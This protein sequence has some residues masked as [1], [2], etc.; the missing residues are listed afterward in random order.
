[1]KD[2]WWQGKVTSVLFLNIKSTFPVATPQ[3]LFHNMRMQR[4]PPQ[5]IA[6]LW[7]KL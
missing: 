7:E 6:W 1:M 2:A 3:C 4:V 5:I